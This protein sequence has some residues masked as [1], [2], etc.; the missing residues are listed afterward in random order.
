MRQPAI[1]PRPDHIA[2]LTQGLQL[3]LPE[4]QADHLE[5]IADGLLRAYKDARGLA[6]FS[7]RGLV[8][9]QCN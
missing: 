2:A 3:P 8:L 1:R 5:I 6:P 9:G 7:W 4:I